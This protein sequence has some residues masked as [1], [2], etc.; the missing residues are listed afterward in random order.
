MTEEERIEE[1]KEEEKQ[2]KKVLSSVTI[3]AVF[4]GTMTYEFENV[5]YEEAKRLAKEEY[6]LSDL[7]DADIQLEQLI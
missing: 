7:S 1:L 4:R 3:T 6:R 2:A 5:T